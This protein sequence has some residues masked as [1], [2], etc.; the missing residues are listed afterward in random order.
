LAG[1]LLFGL[2]QPNVL[3][4]QGIP[5]LAYLAFVPVFLLTRRVPWKA[6]VFAGFVYGVVSY[7]FFTYWLAVF[8]PLGIFVIS[9]MYGVYLMVV[10]PLLKACTVLFPKKGWVLQWV[11]WV[12]YEYVK[13]LGFTGFHYGVTA[14]SHWRFPALRQIA[15]VTGVWGLSAL[16]VFTSAWLSRVLSEAWGV[17]Q[18]PCGRHVFAVARTHWRSA[19]VWAVCFAAVLIYGFVS[20]GDYSKTPSMSAVLV[21]HNSDPWKSGEPGMD[22]VTAYRVDLEVLQK[23]TDRA[24][25]E[26][27]DAGFVVWPETAFVPRITWHYRHRYDGRK[28]A[29]VDDLLRYLDARNV[30]FVIGND[31]AVDGYNRSGMRDVIDYNAVMVFEGGKNVIPPEPQVYAKMHLVP[32]TEYFPFEKQFPALYQGL[33]NGDT[34]MWEP[35]KEAAVFTIG[36]LRFSTPVCFEDT[37]GYIGRRF[38]NQGARAFVNLSND[39]WSKSLACQYQHLS[40]AVFR[41]VENRV[42]AVRSTTSGQT[43][44][45]DPNGRVTA[46]APPFSREYLAVTVPLVDGDNWQK[47]VDTCFGEWFGVFSV[48]VAVIGL[49]WGVIRKV[50]KWQK[51]KK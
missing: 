10:F 20:P 19:A 16:I 31:H 23:L 11:L 14:Y 43:V 1:A 32:F 50:M 7:C 41:C 29:L 12:A 3:V 38:V 28:F 2:S 30:P 47:T 15:D 42:P 35:G 17:Q 6:I 4:V 37:F 22:E 44:S 26:H 18:G 8:H 33:L 51:Q 40:M 21:Q 36:D 25:A 34:H 49:L 5:I 46:M 48:I 45:I 39:A 13:T 9:A 24:L 27:P